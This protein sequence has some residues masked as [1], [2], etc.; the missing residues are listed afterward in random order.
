M[1]NKKFRKALDHYI[2]MM[3]LGPEE[4]PIILDNHYYDNSIIG[5]TNDN[6]LVYDY[7]KMIREFARDEGCDEIE[8][9]EWVDYNT[10]RAI[11]YMGEMRPIILQAN[12][13]E[14]F[15]HAFDERIF[16]ETEGDE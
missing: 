7:N 1:L 3:D 16:D 12:R 13:R 10:M 15:Q 14:I 8:A 9:Q 2:E 4:C 6:R 11:P 5:I